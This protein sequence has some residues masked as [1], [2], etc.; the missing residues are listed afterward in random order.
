MMRG[1]GRRLPGPFRS[2]RDASRGGR[3]QIRCKRNCLCPAGTGRANRKGPGLQTPLSDP[4]PRHVDGAVHG[5]GSRFT[6]TVSRLRSRVEAGSTAITTSRSWAHARRRHASQGGLGAVRVRRRF[7]A[8]GQILRRV[9]RGVPDV[10]G[11]IPRGVPDVASHVPRR[12]SDGAP[13][14]LQ[15]GASHRTRRCQACQYRHW[16]SAAAHGI[17]S[18]GT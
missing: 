17:S 10:A 7:G 11:D 14:A 13:R 8:I 2:G 12:V 3:N 16:K 9:P 5:N 18:P 15:V 1:P 6:I 4:V